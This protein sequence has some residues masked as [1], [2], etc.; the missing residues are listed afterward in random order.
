MQ[1]LAIKLF[2]H[3]ALNNRQKKI[4]LK[5]QYINKEQLNIVQE[6]E[7]YGTNQCSIPLSSLV[8][9]QTNQSSLLTI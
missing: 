4:A 7:M 6:I 3:W 9:W 8:P 5:S 1:S 2:P